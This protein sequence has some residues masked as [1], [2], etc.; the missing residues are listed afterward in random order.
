MSAAALRRDEQKV[1]GFGLISI[2]PMIATTTFWSCRW[3]DPQLERQKD[4]HDVLSSSIYASTGDRWPR[5]LALYTTG[6]ST[7]CEVG[8]LWRSK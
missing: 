2:A 3:I 5:C 1:G 6:I 4:S 7:S 8:F